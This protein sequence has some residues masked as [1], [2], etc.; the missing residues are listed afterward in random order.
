MRTPDL[1][2]LDAG[3]VVQGTPAY[4]LFRGVP[5]TRCMSLMR[6][7]AVALGNHDLD[8]GPSAWIGSARTLRFRF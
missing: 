3:D 1:I 8:D 7:D 4:N 2:L 6:Y 5:D